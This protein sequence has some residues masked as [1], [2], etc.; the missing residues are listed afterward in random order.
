MKNVLDSVLEEKHQGSFEF[1]AKDLKSGADVRW[2]AGC[3]DFSVLAQVQR[4]MPTLGIAKENI[5]VISGIGCSSRFPYYMDTY[6]MH[7]LHGRALAI[8]SGLKIARPELSVWVATGDGDCMSIGGNHF[9][10]AA[11]RNVNMNVL[12]FNNGIYS[13]T[14]GQY[15]PLSLKGQITKSS[16]LGVLDDPFNASALALGAGSSFVARSYD[17]D[18]KL[19]K[20]VLER[21]ARHNGFAFV[22]IYSNCVIFNDGAYDGYTTKENRFDNT[23][24]LEHG[25]P[26][27]FGKDLEKGIKLDG[28]RPT[29]VSL[30]DGKHSKDDLL[31]HDEAD[32]TLAAILADMT[33]N[34]TVP[35]PMGVFHAVDRTP[36]DQ[37]TTEQLEHYAIQPGAG[38]MNALLKGN[39]SW[40]IK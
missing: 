20:V 25:M 1:T 27:V 36:Y 4:I 34:P 12:M 13:L 29:V 31:I 14:K 40:E 30:T 39:D 5:A 3:G 16:P 33:Y 18:A 26:L 21:A 32:T 37:R 6:G 7:T 9:I 24:N 19:M 11:R 23:V 8:A 22:E 17:K 38:D 2:C 28:F 35:Q 10:H 15:S